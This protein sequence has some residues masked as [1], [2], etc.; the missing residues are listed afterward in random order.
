LLNKQYI[1]L[2]PAEKQVPE[3]EAEIFQKKQPVSILAA[4]IAKSVFCL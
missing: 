3:K 4:I 2:F 1:L